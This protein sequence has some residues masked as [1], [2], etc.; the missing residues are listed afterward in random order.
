MGLVAI[1][2]NHANTTVAMPEQASLNRSTAQPLNRLSLQMRPIRS[3]TMTMMRINPSPPLGPYPQLRLCGHDGITPM[4]A[5]TS[6][7]IRIVIMI[8]P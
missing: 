6:T 2:T 3:S 4:S 7:M 8:P 5:S 1:G